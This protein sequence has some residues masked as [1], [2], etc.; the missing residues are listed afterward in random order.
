MV[1]LG[2]DLGLGLDMKLDC[3]W[4]THACM[5][6]PRTT[7]G[8]RLYHAWNMPVSCMECACTTHG[9]CL[10]RILNIDP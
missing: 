8:I 7:H 1:E 6:Y 3:A 2:L 4:C 5:E 9:I 10:Y